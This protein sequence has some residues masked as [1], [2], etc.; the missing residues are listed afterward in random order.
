MN[1]QDALKEIKTIRARLEELEKIVQEPDV[2]RLWTPLKG[3][4]Y[5]CIGNDGDVFHSSFGN[6]IYDQ[7]RIAFGNC[8]PTKGAAEKALPMFTRSHKIIQAA[9]QV[10]PDAGAFK[11]GERNWAV[12]F[13]ADDMGW[14]PDYWGSTDT[15]LPFF[16]TKEQAV[17]IAAIL[18]AEGV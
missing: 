1:K 15:G 17:R 14:E 18:N 10:D 2:E 12:Y 16:H 8:F 9:L 5:W 6:D 3:S 7:R 11:Y 13:H 4:G